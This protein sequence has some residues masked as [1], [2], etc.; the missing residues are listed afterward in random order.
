MELNPS[1]C[2]TGKHIYDLVSEAVDSH[3]IQKSRKFLS[4]K[5]T[6]TNDANFFSKGMKMT[7]DKT[8]EQEEDIMSLILI[9]QVSQPASQP[10]SQSVSQSV[11]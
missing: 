6:T 4:T 10:A 1:I 9:E 5:T 7:M 11:S 2:R 8:T 3:Q